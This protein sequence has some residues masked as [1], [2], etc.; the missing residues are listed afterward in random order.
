[1]LFLFACGEPEFDNP[2]DPDNPDFEIPETTILSGPQ[3]GEIVD[4]SSVTFSWEGNEQAVEYAFQL[5][6]GGWSLWT[7]EPSITLNYLDEGD[8]YFQVKSRYISE[9]EDETP[10]EIN[11]TVDAVHGPALRVFPLLTTTSVSQPTIIEIYMEEVE[12]IMAS[13]FSVSYNP[14][15][16]TVESVSKGELLSN[17]N[18]ES[19]LIYETQT[20]DSEA[21]IIFDIGVA[22]RGNAG[23]IGSGS[24]ISIEF[25]PVSI[26]DFDVEILTESTFRDNN[27]LEII[28]N[29]SKNGRFEIE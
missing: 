23:L 7:K 9:D 25:M 19:V 10:A 18:G 2:V 27:N 12:N 20:V 4:T 14:L 29:Q 11:F 13:E 22:T 5:N 17:Y 1:M 6:E 8:H 26:G 28:V 15:L 24:I 16:V 3:E 21:S